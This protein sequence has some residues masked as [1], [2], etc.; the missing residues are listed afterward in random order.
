[1]GFVGRDPWASKKGVFLD[2]LLPN[3][4]EIAC[5]F[6][7]HPLFQC[8]SSSLQGMQREEKG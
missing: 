2:C 7:V 3:F 1:M 6:L 8:H 4:S 5:Q